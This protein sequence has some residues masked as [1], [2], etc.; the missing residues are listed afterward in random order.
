[1]PATMR[2][3]LRAALGDAAYGPRS[4]MVSLEVGELVEVHSDGR[5]T[6]RQCRP[7]DAAPARERSQVVPYAAHLVVAENEVQ[8]PGC[9]SGRLGHR[10]FD[11]ESVARTLVNR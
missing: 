1:M 7:G 5:V 9:R 6:G 8:V 2:R 4:A 10:C 3:R 11:R